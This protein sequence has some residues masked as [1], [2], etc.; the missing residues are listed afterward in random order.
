MMSVPIRLGSELSAGKPA[1]VFERAGF[2]TTASLE[3]RQYDV[4]PD[5]K[6]FVMVELPDM[7]APAQ[8]LMLVTNWFAEL[9]RKVNG[10]TK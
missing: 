6:S 4:A 5:G 10:A 2:Y 9:E 7:Q 8:P 3:A 1:V